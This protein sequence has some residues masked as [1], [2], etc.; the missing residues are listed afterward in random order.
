[1]TNSKLPT[2][3]MK[4]LAR[5]MEEEMN[6]T[7]KGN[8]W[9]ENQNLVLDTLERNTR[10]IENLRDDMHA[11]RVEVTKDIATLKVK[12]GMWGAI[13]GI[14]TAIPIAIAIASLMMKAVPATGTGG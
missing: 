11:F 14:I 6:M 5:E 2:F 1:M 13:A 9:H 3:S 12:S 7:D 10:S 4:E 8:G